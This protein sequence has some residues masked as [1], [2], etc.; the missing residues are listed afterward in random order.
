MLEA[1]RGVD[2]GVVAG[3]SHGLVAVYEH[4]HGS[5][6]AGLRRSGGQ[7]ARDDAGGRAVRGG[8][9]RVAGIGVHG[10]V[11]AQLRLD[12]VVVHGHGYGA[13]QAGRAAAGDDGAR[14]GLHI[15]ILA[16]QE[17]QAVHQAQ[18][19]FAGDIHIRLI[20][21]PAVGVGGLVIVDQTGVGAGA[22]LVGEVAGIGDQRAQVYKLLEVLSRHGL[23][24][25]VQLE[26]VGGDLGVVAHGG[27]YGVLADDDVAGDAHAHAGAAGQADAARAGS[28]PGLVGGAHGNAAALE[29]PGRFRAAAGDVHGG[30]A[31]ADQHA[32]RAAQRDAG[33]PARHGAGER[34]G[35]QLAG[36]VAGEVLAQVRGGAHVAAAC[37]DQVP[38]HADVG[39]VAVDT[40]GHA[41][42]DGI[43]LLGEGHGRA[44]ALG[45][46]IADVLGRG[47]DAAAGLDGPD[48]G[49][50]GVAR[51]VDAHD[52]ADLH[53]GAGVQV[54]V[55]EA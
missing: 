28:E 43:G 3:L 26:A 29:L 44:G 35:G 47:G 51:H 2:I 17:V 14:D 27:L 50:H 41:E 33:A 16:G 30:L 54:L 48:L 49:L 8:H 13:G 12:V 38:V 11:V 6:H 18:Q 10:D 24:L 9:V 1:A 20:G 39:L 45:V 7:A 34:L 32:D 22:L 5:A 19:L 46:E 31:L 40:D 36:E 55:S 52:R 15:G 25:G 21:G 42:G 4:G 53:L 23:L 37:G